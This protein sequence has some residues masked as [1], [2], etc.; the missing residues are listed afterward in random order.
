[1]YLANLYLN[2]H[3]L[4]LFGKIGLVTRKNSCTEK[5][6]K[7]HIAENGL[8]LLPNSDCSGSFS[9]VYDSNDGG[10]GKCVSCDSYGYGLQT[11]AVKC[12]QADDYTQ[13]CEYAC[14]A[15]GE[16]DEKLPNTN[17]C[18]GYVW[19]N[20]GYECVHVA[21]CVKNKCGVQCCSDTDCLG[22]DSTTHTK[23][24]C[25]SPS[26]SLHTNNDYT[27][28]KL[29]SCGDNIQCDSTYCC[30]K[31][32]GYG[33]SCVS[34]GLYP[35]NTKYLCTTSS[36]AEWHECNQNNLNEQIENH[37]CTGKG[38]VSLSNEIETEVQ[39]IQNPIFI[40]ILIGI[41]TLFLFI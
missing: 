18:D 39:K 27:C 33:G 37:I 40:I 8:Q 32:I 14:G 41:S 15:D 3:L 19:H 9:G 23:M 16:C 38:W 22:Y 7:K 36:P 25:D 21:G 24:V 30:D 2:I 13:K 1:M 10:V 6:I 35:A 4:M 34:R 12:G 29:P 5:K 31:N 17:W 11:Q 20:C 26:G 28:K